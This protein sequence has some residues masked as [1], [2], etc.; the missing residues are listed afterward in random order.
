MKIPGVFRTLWH[1]TARRLSASI[2]RGSSKSIKLK[3]T[4]SGDDNGTSGEISTAV[5][6]RAGMCGME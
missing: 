3:S 4:D 1:S 2:A 5:M 6:L